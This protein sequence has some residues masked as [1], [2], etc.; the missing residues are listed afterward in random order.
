MLMTSRSLVSA[1]SARYPSIQFTALASIADTTPNTLSAA[2]AATSKGSA[3]SYLPT[4][5]LTRGSGHTKGICGTIGLLTRP[6][7]AVRSRGD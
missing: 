3:V 2:R 4:P 1:L 6:P 7:L 5:E